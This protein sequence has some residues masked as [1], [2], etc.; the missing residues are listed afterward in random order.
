[1]PRSSPKQ[2]SRR[3]AHPLAVVLGV[4]GALLILLFSALFFAKSAAQSWLRGE[5]FRQWALAHLA[6]AMHAE[7]E[8]SEFAWQGSELYVDRFVARGE[9]AAAFSSLEALGFRARSGGIRHGAY[10][11]PEVSANR[12]QLEFS[13]DRVAS[14]PDLSPPP[15]DAADAAGHALPPWLRRWLPDRVEIDS[16]R[17]DSV[18]V[19][20]RQPDGSVPF[21]LAGASATIQPDFV[22]GLWQIDAM[23]G[24]VV[25]PHRDDLRLEDLRLRW[26]GNDLFVDRCR[27]GVFE[28]GQVSGSGEI[29]FSEGGDFDLALEFAS[30]PIAELLQGEWGERLSGTLNGPVEL[31]GRP[32]DFRYEGEIRVAEGVVRSFPALTMIA[33]YTRNEQFKHLVLSEARSRFLHE[34]ELVRLTGLV[35][36]SDGLIRVEGDLDIRGR[37]LEGLLQVGVAPGTLSWIPGAERQVFTEERGGFLWTPVH[38]TGTTEA[39]REDLSARLVLAAGEAVLRDLPGDALEQLQRFLPEGTE[40]PAGSEQLLEQAKPLLDLITPF[41]SRP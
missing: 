9:E 34:G 3:K 22:T 27:V 8:V 26:K 1:M 14:R 33:N 11:I 32:G 36:Q 28:H 16:I 40:L 25:L 18:G 23:G 12:L 4:C 21:A 41:L 30:L 13:D 7:L 39:P 2:R 10:L 37:E 31:T 19:R 24:R 15:P 17:V 5:G 35:L 29:D 38:L 20:V 6:P